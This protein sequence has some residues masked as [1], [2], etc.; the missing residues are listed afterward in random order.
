M[1]TYPDW[2]ALRERTAFLALEDGTIIRG[3]SCG[4]PAD[5]LGEVV[6][7]TGMTGY[8][9]IL[10]DPS[11]AGQIV[12][13]TA[14]EIGNTGC[15]AVDM[16]SA[17]CH[18]AGFIIQNLNAPSNF[19]AEDSLPA[20]L[21][22][23]NMP[24]LTGVDTRALTI[25]LRQQGTMKAMLCTTGRISP[26]QAVRQ[27][28]DWCGLDGQDYASRVTCSEPYC[29]D[30][31]GSLSASWGIGEQI[32]EPDMHIVAYDFGIKRNI[33]RRLRLAGFR[34]TV[35]PAATAAAQVRALR[36][37]GVLLSNGPADPAAV[38]YAIDNARQLLG[39]LPLM[40]I[41]L[42]HQLLG[43]AIGGRTYRLKY[44]HHG[45]N[46]PVKDLTTGTVEITSQNHNFAIDPDSL[47]AKKVDITHLNLN[48]QTV[49]GLSHA[50]E[51]LMC[52]QYHPEAAPGPHDPTY[53][54]ARF[55][56]LIENA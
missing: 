46:H 17:G 31:D 28:R 26:A 50:R 21:T 3:A 43:I 47:D 16:E 53:L 41:C 11:Y 40:G 29:W 14:P 55:R 20:L 56:T 44:G 24:A 25:R 27:A 38:T 6:F 22:A 49:E 23:A 18:A 13:M 5:Q 4:A 45:C 33:L 52:V 9:E 7:N 19:R 37:D 10:S 42:G 34:V 36:P 32:P 35:V 12:V 30:A 2:R 51:P 15:T 8:Q 48:D 54:F 1:S 39:H